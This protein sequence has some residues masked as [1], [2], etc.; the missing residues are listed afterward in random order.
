MSRF[1][2]GIYP[3]HEDAAAKRRPPHAGALQAKDPGPP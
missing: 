1:L 3:Y 2:I